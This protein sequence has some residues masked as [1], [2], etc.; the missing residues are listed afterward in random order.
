MYVCGAS[1]GQYSHNCTF[2][3]N[4]SIVIVFTIIC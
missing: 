3:V 4:K 1:G 2:K